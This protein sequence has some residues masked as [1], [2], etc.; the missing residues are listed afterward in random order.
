MTFQNTMNTLFQDELG[1]FV[2]IYIDDI[3]IFSKTYKE[4]INHVRHVLKKLRDN[5]FYTDR[6]K[7]Q[8]LPEELSILGHAITRR[9]I[10]LVPGRV[11]KILDWPTPS[12]IKEL[13]TLLG[14]VN[15][16]SQ[17]ALQLATI[18]SPLTAMAGSTANWDWTYTY[19]KSFE[20]IKQTL[21]ADPAVRPLDYK[22]TDP[23]FLVTD[24]SLLGT[25]AWVG[26]GP[27]VSEIRPAAFHIRKFNSAQL[28]YSTF[29][30]KLLAIVDTLEHF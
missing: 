27:S 29:D 11:R 20:L 3:F 7:S 9:G 12:N 23:I 13:Q 5:Q 19:Q 24:A 16:C 25:G 18:S 28:N 21:S 26:Q 1:L 15:Y 6:K 8:F 30:K 2:Y 22:S 17:F 4:H 14:M 10:Q